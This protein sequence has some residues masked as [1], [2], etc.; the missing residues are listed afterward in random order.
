[1][2][3]QL[4]VARKLNVDLTT[5]SKLDRDVGKD[6]GD[7][8]VDLMRAKGLMFAMALKARSTGVRPIVENT[9]FAVVEKAELK[10]GKAVLEIRHRQQA[11][12]RGKPY[13]ASSVTNRSTERI[14]IDRF[15]TYIQKGQTLVLHS[16]TGGF[17]SAQQFREWYGMD[18][19][20]IEPGQTVTDTNSHSN[21]GVYWVYFGVSQSGK[22]F[23]SGAVW[24]GGGWF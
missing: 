7:S 1:M 20:W 21:L 5:E 17:L 2:N 3:E 15:G 4:P 12:D 9:I 10:A 11:A 24:K 13:Y 14:R 22:E 8:S 18:E 23:V 6:L 19:E 16:L